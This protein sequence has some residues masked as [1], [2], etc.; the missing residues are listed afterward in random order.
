MKPIILVGTIAITLSLILYSIAIITILLKKEITIKDVILLTVGIVSEISA[1]ACMAMGSSKPITTPHG[2]TGL[3]GLLIMVFIVI[4]SWKTILPSK[5]TIQLQP[6][7]KK[8]LWVG[9]GIWIVAF[10]SGAAEGMRQV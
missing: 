9:Y 6:R 2:L 4:N 7:F 10:L 8:L 5:D 3:A 1:V